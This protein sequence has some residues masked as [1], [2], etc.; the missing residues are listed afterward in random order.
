[1]SNPFKVSEKEIDLFLGN[2]KRVRKPMGKQK[3]VMLVDKINKE[4]KRHVSVKSRHKFRE[5]LRKAHGVEVEDYA[6]TLNAQDLKCASCGKDL[7]G[8]DVYDNGRIICR[9]CHSNV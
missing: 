4:T 2:W 9:S 6:R 1:M 7:V 8:N 5:N 3:N